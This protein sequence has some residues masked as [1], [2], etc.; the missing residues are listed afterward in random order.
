M[1]TNTNP[2]SESDLKTI[3][4]ELQTRRKY[5]EQQRLSKI[6][7]TVALRKDVGSHIYQSL[8][9][10]TNNTNTNYTNN[11]GTIN[12]SAST[13]SND[14]KHQPQP[15]MMVPLSGGYMPTV[16]NNHSPHGSQGQPQPQLARTMTSTTVSQTNRSIPSLVPVPTVHHHPHTINPIHTVQDSLP[17]RR[18]QATPTA[19]VS[20]AALYPPLP[21]PPPPS[22]PEE[23]SLV[24][25][26]YQPAIGNSSSSNG[27]SVAT[28]IPARR[29][30]PSRGSPQRP[31]LN[32]NNG[33]TTTSNNNNSYNFNVTDSITSS[34]VNPSILNDDTAVVRQRL[35]ETQPPSVPLNSSISLSSST[36]FSNAS[37]VSRSVS[38]NERFF[39]PKNNNAPSSSSMNIAVSDYE[40]RSAR[41]RQSKSS[42][43]S[44]AAVSTQLPSSMYAH[45]QHH[46][47]SSSP[48]TS[49]TVS[50]TTFHG[51]SSSA[52]S[53]ASWSPSVSPY[54]TNIGS[55][56]HNYPSNPSLTRDD[57]GNP[58][59][60]TTHLPDPA[61]PIYSPHRSK[62][63]EKAATTYTTN[64][65]SSN[66][67]T[68]QAFS[69]SS[70]PNN[71]YDN[72]PFTAS[73]SRIID[74]TRHGYEGSEAGRAATRKINSRS[75]STTTSRRSSVQRYADTVEYETAGNF[76]TG[77]NNNH[78]VD[79]AGRVGPVLEHVA[80]AVEELQQ[81]LESG[82]FTN[83]G[84][85]SSR[86][87]SSGQTTPSLRTSPSGELTSS[88]D[89]IEGLP[90]GYGEGGRAAKVNARLAA[91]RAKKESEDRARKAAWA[92]ARSASK[93]AAQEN[94]INEWEDSG[95]GESI[96]SPSI[97][98][99][100]LMSSP[101]KVTGRSALNAAAVSV[102]VEPHSNTNASRIPRPPAWGTYHSTSSPDNTK[103]GIPGIRKYSPDQEQLNNRVKFEDETVEDENNDTVGINNDDNFI[104]DSDTGNPQGS[105]NSLAD[106]F[107]SRKRSTSTTK[108]PILRR[109]VVGSVTT[110]SPVVAPGPRQKMAPGVLVIS[111]APAPPVTVASSAPTNFSPPAAN[112][113]GSAYMNEPKVSPAVR[114][115]TVSPLGRRSASAGKQSSLAAL[116]SATSAVVKSTITAS[117][118]GGHGGSSTASN[119]QKITNALTALC[120][121]GPHRSI[122]L[123]T[124]LASMKSC[125]SSN[126]LLL[127]ASPESLS[128]RGLYSFEPH[129]GTCLRLHGTGPATLTSAIIAAMET[130][131]GKDKEKKDTIVTSPTDSTGTSWI[132]DTCFKY[133]TSSRSFAH[134]PSKEVTLTTD[135]ITIRVRYTTTTNS[136]NNNGGTPAGSSRSVSRNRNLQGTMSG[137]NSA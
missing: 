15:F 109:P 7:R 19:I 29:T 96:T 35:R 24:A 78:R 98:G 30:L 22:V 73:P 136:N 83:K 46:H 3:A 10:S 123:A 77:H 72:D 95:R 126:F 48:L 101:S 17:D 38:P 61:E 33:T 106:A 118:V 9:Q 44:T 45:Q 82:R 65:S 36:T 23:P 71:N 69:I 47:R 111:P 115:R 74:G 31:L 4:L 103:T 49:S 99:V 54:R 1:A 131:P 76:R 86:S 11:I 67:R 42:L 122:E 124:A 32:N 91:I 132:V 43:S 93:I 81:A 116:A 87:P 12:Y 21:P 6:E 85:S 51:P 41:L 52:T 58:V 88:P 108:Q 119:R 68:S 92:A 18:P 60:L 28:N 125:E 59:I 27:T 16:D 137:V 56:S 39:Q 104:V 114:Q 97:A 2:L 130:S 133:V 113:I 75:P 70:E 100:V 90:F 89:P 63:P 34:M 50:T 62:H 127:L 129:N 40:R 110:S 120:L 105:T 117:G 57:Y 26:L 37:N 107:A 94:V 84:I 53:S 64:N 134:I 121:A 79:H 128:Y 5:I 14:N 66:M 102:P 55:S 25:K 135:A 13:F 8:M 20:L 80:A 112:Y